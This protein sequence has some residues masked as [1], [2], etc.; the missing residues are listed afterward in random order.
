[1]LKTLAG[2]GD[3]LFLYIFGLHDV[4]KQCYDVDMIYVYKLMIDTTQMRTLCF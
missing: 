1:M 2:C 3:S 4:V